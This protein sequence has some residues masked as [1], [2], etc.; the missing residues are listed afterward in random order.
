MFKKKEKQIQHL[1]TIKV[2]TN[3]IQLAEKVNP[4]T[5]GI[6]VFNSV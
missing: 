3:H 4:V 2:N 5:E 6:H 1:G